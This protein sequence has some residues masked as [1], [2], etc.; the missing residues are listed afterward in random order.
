MPALVLCS[1]QIRA[2]S[3]GAL[4]AGLHAGN[5]PRE[6]NL[7][8]PFWPVGYVPRAKRELADKA[9]EEKEKETPTQ[10]A[11][12]ENTEQIR[13]QLLVGGFIRSGAEL[14]VIINDQVVRPGDIVDI[15]S[16]GIKHR[17]IV[18]SLS[19]EEIVLEPERREVT[20]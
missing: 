19:E 8:D 7:R 5:E 16:K 13:S 17:F 10:V 20:L 11:D 9:E 18:R 12:V 1:E 3:P 14:C 2:E 15:K 6:P 4:G